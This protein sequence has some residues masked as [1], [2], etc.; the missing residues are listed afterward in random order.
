LT[1]SC[2]FSFPFLPLPY[3]LLP[4]SSP[5]SIEHIRDLKAFFGTT[6][7]IKP[8]IAALPSAADEDDGDV[9]MGSAAAAKAPAAESY[10]F[11]CVG[12]GFTNTAKRA[13]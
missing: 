12:T 6:F 7:K 8:V 2:S 3:F 11:S 5:S 4:S 10:I 9:E 13:G 1:L